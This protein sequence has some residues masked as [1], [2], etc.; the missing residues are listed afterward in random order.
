M[1]TKQTIA[2]IGATGKMGSALSKT[3]AKSNY[4]LLLSDL[5]KKEAGILA[6]KIRDQIPEADVEAVECARNACWEADIIIPALP[7]YSE[8]EIA[9]T[10]REV[11]NQ[12]IVISVS[13]P[14]DDSSNTLLTKKGSSAGE[15]LQKLLP[16][17]KVVK[18]FNTIFAADLK[19]PVMKGMQADT[20]LAGNDEEALENVADIVRAAGLNPL[21]TGKLSFSRTLESMQ[22]L[23][24]QLSRRYQFNNTASWKILYN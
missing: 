13:N 12:K 24:I 14:L 17:S 2:I 1:G 9:E 19:H 20:F 16:H 6:K 18:A 23:M 22:L 3:L 11:A 21:I 15:E 4:R 8:K 10:I 7:F 5:H